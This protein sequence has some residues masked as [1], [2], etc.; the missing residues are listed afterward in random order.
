MFWGYRDARTSR[1][2]YVNAGHCPPLL[3]RAQGQIDELDGGGPVLGLLPHARYEQH[4]AD[5]EA[6]DVLV[7]YS[8]GLV[9]ATN[10]ADEQF[11][12]ERVREAVA[13][14]RG[15][16]PEEIRGAIFA[17]VHEFTGGAGFEDDLTLAVLSFEGERAES[18]DTYEL[19][20]A[21]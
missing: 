15:R 7:L 13:C 2:H 18:A 4:V 1:L 10:G 14:S 19:A 6:D 20:A 8:D 21:C 5:V 12:F 11:G 3:L 9:E 17:A 16:T